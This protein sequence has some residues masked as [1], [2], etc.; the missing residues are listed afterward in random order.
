MAADV[1]NYPGRANFS[2]QTN[3]DFDYTLTWSVNDEP[4]DLTNAAALM[5]LRD[6][7]DTPA[8]LTLTESDGITLG[9]SA[10]TIRI[11][12]EDTQFADLEAG[13]YDYDLLISL[14][15]DEVPLIRGTFTLTLGVSRWP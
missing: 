15:N 7:P 1:G 10:G 8:V 5:Q 11:R 14:S 9:G 13:V 4:V 12:I 6:E 2:A 3:Q